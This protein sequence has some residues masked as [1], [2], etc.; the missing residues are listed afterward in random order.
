MSMRSPALENLLQGLR[1]HPA[2]PELLAAVSRP[3][4]P[5]FKVSQVASAHEANA[6]WIYESGR[7]AAHEAWVATLTGKPASDL[8]AK[9]D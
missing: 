8:T 5:R 3:Q 2:F 6:K 4:L 9:E 1:Q 7:L